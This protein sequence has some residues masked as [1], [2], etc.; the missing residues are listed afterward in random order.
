MI[1][2]G[3]ICRKGLK[4]LGTDTCEQLL[5]DSVYTESRMDVM[6]AIA[7]ISLDCFRLVT[8]L[9]HGRYCEGRTGLGQVIPAG[10][11]KVRLQMRIVQAIWRLLR[12]PTLE[13]LLPIGA[14]CRFGLQT[15]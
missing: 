10:D 15:A 8:F 4:K 14:T 9:G 7:S 11:E 1:V 6:I 5:Q 12:V 2:L 3:R 13:T